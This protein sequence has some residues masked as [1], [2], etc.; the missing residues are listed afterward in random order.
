MPPHAKE[1][2]L[3]S[4][5]YF[6]Y[7]IFSVPRGCD[8]NLSL[9]FIGITKTSQLD[10]AAC[11]FSEQ[12]RADGRCVVVARRTWAPEKIVKEQGVFDV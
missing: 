10:A 9:F 6:F 2:L 8:D 5:S 11:L 12:M 7:G 4:S 1:Q 3:V